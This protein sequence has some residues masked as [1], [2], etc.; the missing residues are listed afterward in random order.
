MCCFPSYNNIVSSYKFLK[1]QVLAL[2]PVLRPFTVWLS[3][4]ADKVFEQVNY[5]KGVFFLTGVSK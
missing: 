2:H 4:G 5:Y 3:P 1:R